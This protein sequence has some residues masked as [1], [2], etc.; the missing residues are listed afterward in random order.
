MAFLIYLDVCCLNRPFDNQAQER[1]RLESEAVLLILT[2]CQ[3]REWFLLGSEAID[4]EIAQTLD[5][6][7]RQRLIA[8]AS[9]ATTKATVTKQ[10]ESRALEVVRL[11][12]KPYDALHIA[13]AE[14]GNAD[15]LL[16]TDDRLIRKAATYDNMLQV[17][18]QNPILWLL[19]VTNNGNA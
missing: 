19:E 12:C 17:R 18:V 8:L 9:L 14:A 4:A 11:G 10:V 13:C 2:R 3:S 15:I 1:V 7:R 16:T 6:D 5:A